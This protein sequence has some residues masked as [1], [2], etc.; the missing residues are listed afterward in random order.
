MPDATTAMSHEQQAAAEFNTAMSHLRSVFERRED[1]LA[2]TA[3]TEAALRFG[4]CELRMRL[5]GRLKVIGLAKTE[6]NELV[7]SAMI[8]NKLGLAALPGM[9]PLVERLSNEEADEKVLRLWRNI[10]PQLRK[11]WRQYLA[12]IDVD[13]SEARQLVGLADDVCIAVDRGGVAGLGRHLADRLDELE[14]IR[15]SKNRGTQAES[16]PYWKIACAAVV[17]GMGVAA[18]IALLRE[19]APWY[20]PALMWLLI[21]VVTFCI[22]LGC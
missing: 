11:E 2:V 13:A 4:D 21:A 10:S 22:A 16:F 17:W 12:D 9:Q 20:R 3:L 1:Q 7:K 15:R 6:A 8:E 5:A 19:G 14:K 18:T